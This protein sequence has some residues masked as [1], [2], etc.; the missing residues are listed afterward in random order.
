MNPQY[1]I[2]LLFVA[3]GTLVFRFIF[4]GRKNPP[5]LPDSIKCALDYVPPVVLSAM[6]L[7]EFINFSSPNIP[8]MA[9]G[10]AAAFAVFVFNRDFLAIVVGFLVY[11]LAA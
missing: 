10:L 5:K 6:V 9:A 1:W 7:P 8:A 3:L 4:L 11:L 2:A